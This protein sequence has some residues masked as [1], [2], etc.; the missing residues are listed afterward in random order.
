MSIL[1]PP[2]VAHGGNQSE[3]AADNT[4][5]AN[6]DMALGYIRLP[7]QEVR[8]VL[9]LLSLESGHHSTPSTRRC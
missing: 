9:S 5:N 6:I 4:Q 2:T 8:N 7:G 1:A 3:V